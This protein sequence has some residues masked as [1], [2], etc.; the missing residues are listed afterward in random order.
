MPGGVLGRVDEWVRLGKTKQQKKKVKPVSAHKCS[1]GHTD[2]VWWAKAETW[3][4]EEEGVGGMCVRCWAGVMVMGSLSYLGMFRELD[5]VIV[6]ETTQ[7]SRE[8]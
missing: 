7:G 4:R 5:G 8:R 6:K 1:L 3:A 2:G